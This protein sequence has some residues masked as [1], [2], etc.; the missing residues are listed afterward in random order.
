MRKP[1]HHSTES[2]TA[3]GYGSQWRKLRA[4]VMKR[5]KGLCQPCFKA[6]RVTLATECD[7]ITPKHKGGTNDD[8]NLQSIC[9][10][11]HTDKTARE[12][13][14]AQGRRIKVQIGLDGWPVE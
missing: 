5:D 13:A 11:C 4:S 2:N 12:S 8:C 1:W 9:G 14:E 6:G 7:H 10:P 3:R